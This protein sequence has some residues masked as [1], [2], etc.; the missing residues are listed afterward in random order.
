MKPHGI[1]KSRKR[2]QAKVRAKNEK[3]PF[4]PIQPFYRSH[5]RNKKRIQFLLFK[6]SSNA[7]S[8]RGGILFPSLVDFVVF[9]ILAGKE[10]AR[11]FGTALYVA[12]ACCRCLETGFSDN[13]LFYPPA[14]R[15]RYVG[16]MD[17]LDIFVQSALS[18][19]SPG[20]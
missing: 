8:D 2:M 15:L 10:R 3:A 12:F 6:A 16:W 18:E 13:I 5:G 14:Q 4:R 19:C 20:S 11:L 1:R 9:G 7:Y 17:G